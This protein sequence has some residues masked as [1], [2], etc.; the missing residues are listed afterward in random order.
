[1]NTVSSSKSLHAAMCL[2]AITS[3]SYCF[4]CGKNLYKDTRIMVSLLYASLL[5]NK[6]PNIKY[7]I[8]VFFNEARYKLLT[9]SWN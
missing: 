7:I 6:L 1:M 5:L 3:E 4:F 9:A 8:D 2:F